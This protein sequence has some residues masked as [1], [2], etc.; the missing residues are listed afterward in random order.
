MSST[1]I[2]HFA[3]TLAN[4]DAAAV[5][6]YEHSTPALIRHVVKAL[7]QRED[8]DDFTGKHTGHM[9]QE[10]MAYHPQML[11][12][13]MRLKSARTLVENLVWL[14]RLCM[15]KG[16][17]PN[18]FTIEIPIWKQAV[19][20]VLD[21][22]NA[23]PIQALYQTINES[24]RDLLVLSQR[25]PEQVQVDEALIAHFHDYLD[26]LLAPDGRKALQVSKSFIQ[27]VQDI[28]VWWEQIICPSLYEIGRLW[29]E[30]KITVGQEHMATSITQRVMSAYY[31]M[32]LDLPRQRGTMVIAVS[33]GEL[34]EIGARMLADML[35]MHGWDVYYTGANTPDETLLDLLETLQSR[36]LC[37]STTI[38]SHLGHVSSVISRVKQSSLT[39]PV[40]VV[41]GG[42]AYL[43]DDQLW[44]QVGADGFVPNASQAI[45]YFQTL[46]TGDS[47]NQAARV[48]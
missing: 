42:Q 23:S 14:Y 8:L 5:D 22:S 46:D 38:P 24:H 13:Q 26:A 45:D 19:G 44:A 17:S 47:W 37:I 43:C 10:T 15:N 29:S 40:H 30:G 1:L 11:V 39:V 25:P 31:P 6:A 2:E 48:N 18:Y 16:F 3:T 34:H 36:Y 28:P 35:E 12:A 21:P 4:I 27:Q 41:V 33:Q 9:I 32:I 7:E 20:K